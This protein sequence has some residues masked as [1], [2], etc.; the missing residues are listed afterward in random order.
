MPVDILN[1]PKGGVLGWKDPSGPPTHQFNIA[2]FLL[3]M[4]RSDICPGILYKRN[5]IPRPPDRQ[6]PHN[7]LSFLPNSPFR[8]L[9][10]PSRSVS[11]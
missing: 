1:A 9:T 7:M 8:Y 5:T 6:N 2:A 4:A 3:P 10:T 11:S